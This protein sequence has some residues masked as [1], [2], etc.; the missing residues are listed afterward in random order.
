MLAPLRAG[1]NPA[2]ALAPAAANL[3][4]WWRQ[5]QE[6]TRAGLQDF[7]TPFVEGY[8]NAVVPAVRSHLVHPPA[9]AVNACYS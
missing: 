6:R 9:L 8:Q 5:S 7:L 3:A 2:A 4:D 1:A